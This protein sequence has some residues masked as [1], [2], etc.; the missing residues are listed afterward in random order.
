MTSHRPGLKVIPG[1]IA[2][3]A[4]VE[5]IALSL[6][7]PRERIDIPLGAVRIEACGQQVFA[8]G[9]CPWAIWNPRVEFRFRADIAER[10]ARLTR[11]IVDEPWDIVVGDEVVL[12]PIVREPLCCS[13]TSFM[14]G[15]YNLEEARALAKRLRIGWRKLGPRAVS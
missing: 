12:S 13:G 3:D 4:P 15:A 11:A 1:G 5:R 7:H 10:I 8:E 6:V 14:I 9:G 2:N